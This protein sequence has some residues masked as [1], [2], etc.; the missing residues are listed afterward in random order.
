MN[1]LQYSLGNFGFFLY[2]FFSISAACCQLYTTFWVSKWTE[3]PF[4]EQQKGW[5]PMIFGVLI[6]VYVVL[7]F[8][9]GLTIFLIFITSTTNMHKALVDKLLRSKILFFDSNPIG[10]IFTRL[11]KDVTVLDLMLPKISGLA[12]FTIFRTISVFITVVVVYPWMIPVVLIAL[13]LMG[14]IIY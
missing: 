7:T 14:C 3:E 8:S 12:T 2:F 10:R 13:F 11:S 4:D 9:R 6:V 5:Y 1:L